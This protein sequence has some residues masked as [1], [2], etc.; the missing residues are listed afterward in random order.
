MGINVLVVDDS[1]VM[2]LLIHDIISQDKSINVVDT[3][4]NGK[5]A[6][7]KNNVLNPDVIVMDM[8]M[9]QYDGLY[10]VKEIM[11]TNPKPIL[12]LSSIGNTNLSS[13]IE[14]L[15]AG[16]FDYINKP[17]DHRT[18]LRDIGK[19]IIYKV[20]QASKADLSKLLI[21]T[22]VS[23]NINNHTFSDF[24][25]YDI[26]AVGASTGGPTA[27]EKVIS[28]LPGNLAIPVVIVQHMPENFVPSFVQRLNKLTPLTVEIGKVGTKIIA[29]KIVIAP[30][31]KNMILKKNEAGEVVVS[32]TQKKYKD[33]NNP[34][35]NSVMES[36]AEIYGNRSIGAILTGMGKDGVL[37]ITA[38]KNCGGFTIAQDENTCVV[39]GM[40]KEAIKSGNI[41]SIVPINEIGNFVVSSLS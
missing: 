6:V 4:K 33:Y 17:A 25:P 27:V 12:L 19:D 20:K 9:G 15:N 1:S 34:S 8:I 16:A 5:E 24:L 26:F 23:S 29:G 32:F 13:I 38:I 18:K 30:G 14:A 36:V 10:G 41:D 28:K 22:E 7:E 11:R 31:G 40:P 2:R 35:I 37:G 39:F 21:D 3:A